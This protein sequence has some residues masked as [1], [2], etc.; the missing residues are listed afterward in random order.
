MNDPLLLVAGPGFTR[1]VQKTTDY[2]V[3]FKDTKGQCYD[4]DLKHYDKEWSRSIM[5]SCTVAGVEQEGK[6]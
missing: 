3:E 2:R 4:Q 5:M 1:R 6:L